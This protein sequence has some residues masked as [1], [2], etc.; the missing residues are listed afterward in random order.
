[1]S[2][3]DFTGTLVEGCRSLNPLRPARVSL[4]YE[5]NFGE[6][7]C[8]E[9]S[10]AMKNDLWNKW[11]RL[12][13]KIHLIGFSNCWKL[14]QKSRHSIISS[15]SVSPRQAR[16]I[17]LVTLGQAVETEIHVKQSWKHIPRTHFRA[18]WE[19]P[20][21]FQCL[22]FNIILGDC[23]VGIHASPLPASTASV[24]SVLQ[25]GLHRGTRLNLLCAALVSLC[26]V[27]FHFYSYFIKLFFGRPRKKVWKTG[28]LRS[29]WNRF[30]P[31]TK[32][33]AEAAST[34]CSVWP[35]SQNIFSKIC[36]RSLF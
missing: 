31:F 27:S 21:I 28:S 36:F 12:K 14:C 2:A 5:E 23:G 35:V 13:I 19:F 1:M 15:A 32:I 9:I 25:V 33:R 6:K 8:N 30:R 17:C 4:C 10:D 22:C 11:S 20:V 7:I 16:H 24:L 18:V 29:C 34:T 3:A 26:A